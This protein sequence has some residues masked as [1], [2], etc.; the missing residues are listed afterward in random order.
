MPSP[1]DQ[2]RAARDEAVRAH[3]EARQRVHAAVLEAVE[4][5]IRHQDV[6]DA[7]SITRVT[8]WRWVKQNNEEA[9]RA[10]AR[11]PATHQEAFP[12]EQQ[13]AD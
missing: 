8:L 11:P 2:V 5:G 13:A 12:D 10:N 3:E 1:I 9:G 7:A 4:A 6:A